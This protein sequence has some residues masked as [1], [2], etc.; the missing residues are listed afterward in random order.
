M[1]PV[2]AALADA[3]QKGGWI[4]GPAILLALV[5]AFFKRALRTEGEMNEAL[6]ERDKRYA[7]MQADRDYWRV[8]AQSTLKSL[9]QLTEVMEGAQR[10]AYRP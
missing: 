2:I 3:L 10:S 5:A 8:L 1:D 6:A 9:E 4:S 7:E